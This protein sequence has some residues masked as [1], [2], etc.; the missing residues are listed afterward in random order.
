MLD[1]QTEGDLRRAVR[2]LARHFKT[3]TVI[4]IGSQSILVDWPDAP[5]QMRLSGE[6]DAY[7]AN[8]RAWE[9]ANPGLLASEEI[10]ALFGYDS[11]GEDEAQ[12]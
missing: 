5:V 8:A 10:N 7:P 12:M 1:L 3:D 9:K 4:M 11:D 2:S 6:I